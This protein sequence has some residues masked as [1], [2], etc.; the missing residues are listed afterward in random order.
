MAACS[1]SPGGFLLTVFSTTSSNACQQQA[2][3]VKDGRE[4]RDGRG[5]GREG[6]GEATDLEGFVFRIG[7]KLG[8]NS[9]AAKGQ[10]F[11]CELSRKCEQ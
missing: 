10:P 2:Q 4:R 1:H 8:Q 6:G 11:S 5:R 9:H 3:H 7:H